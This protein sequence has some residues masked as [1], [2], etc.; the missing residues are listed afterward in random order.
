MNDSSR[1]FGG[2]CQ[3][4][5]RH[6]L[7]AN[8]MGIGGIQAPLH[9]WLYGER[10][11][12]EMI[13]GG[14]RVPATRLHAMGTVNRLYAAARLH[15]E[16]LAFAATIAEADPLALRQ[17]KRAVNTSLDIMGQHYIVSRFA[18]L[19]DER[20]SLRWPRTAEPPSGVR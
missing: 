6:F 1:V 7:A 14:T 10:I 16:T 3:S 18:E 4:S 17:A 9:V 15:E 11:A 8:A 19:L 12:K 13:Y 20:P 5:R 2:A